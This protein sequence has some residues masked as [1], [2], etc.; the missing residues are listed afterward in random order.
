M[1]IRVF[2]RYLCILAVCPLST[3]TT[4]LPPSAAVEQASYLLVSPLRSHSVALRRHGDFRAG[5]IERKLLK[6]QALNKQQ[7]FH[8]WQWAGRTARLRIKVWQSNIQLLLCCFLETLFIIT[9]LT[10]LPW[11]VYPGLSMWYRKG[12]N[13]NRIKNLFTRTNSITQTCCL[14]IISC[15]SRMS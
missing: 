4:T 12:L 5:L 3:I 2:L 1:T 14:C 10:N 9:Q 11:L 15:L 7:R 8:V 6:S 13:K